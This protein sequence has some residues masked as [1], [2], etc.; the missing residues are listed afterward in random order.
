MVTR[1]VSRSNMAENNGKKKHERGR[2][3]KPRS[4]G[5]LR[6]LQLIE[7]Q[8]RAESYAKFLSS[9]PLVRAVMK[10]DEKD[11]EKLLNEMGI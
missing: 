1:S 11:I 10:N 9:H 5:A 4:T 8:L 3:R 2:G 7:R 6:E